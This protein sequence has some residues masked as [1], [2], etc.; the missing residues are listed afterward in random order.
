MKNRILITCGGIVVL[1]F[2]ILGA[3]AWYIYFLK[4]SGGFNLNKGNRSTNSSG[5]IFQDDGNSVYDSNATSLEEDEVKDVPSY[6]F[7]VTNIKDNNAEYIL[8]IEDLPVNAINDGCTESTLLKRSQLKYQLSLNGKVIKD[9]KMSNIKD[10]VL[11][12]RVINGNTINTYNLKVYIHDEAEEWLG[13]HYH[14]KVTI[15]K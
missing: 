11:D 4:S 8:Y 3:Y 5:I 14:Y 7:T 13:K 9:D 2:I 12:S 6:K 1:L 10:N 15:N